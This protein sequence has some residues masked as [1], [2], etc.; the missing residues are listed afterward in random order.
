MQENI[1]FTETQ[2]CQICQLWIITE[3]SVYLISWKLCTI[4]ISKWHKE[5]WVPTFT[6][7]VFPFNLSCFNLIRWT[8]LFINESVYHHYFTGLYINEYWQWNIN[9]TYIFQSR[10]YKIVISILNTFPIHKTLDN[11]HTF[12]STM[13]TTKLLDKFNQFSWVQNGKQRLSSTEKKHFLGEL[14]LTP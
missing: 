3:K 4:C 11:P 2:L 1:T 6:F 7:V 5:F 9:G 10:L 13:N 12:P 8:F 14:F